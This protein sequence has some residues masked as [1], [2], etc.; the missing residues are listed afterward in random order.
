MQSLKLGVLRSEAPKYNKGKNMKKMLLLFLS[1]SFLA[2]C[3]RECYTSGLEVKTKYQNCT[4][5]NASFVS[6]VNSE[7]WTIVCLNSKKDVYVYFVHK[8]GKFCR[9]DQNKEKF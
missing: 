3:S 2:S 8:D 1:I 6:D 5:L 9:I 4:D 7:I